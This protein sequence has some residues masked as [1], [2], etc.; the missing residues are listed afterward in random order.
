M[1]L[2]S[3]QLKTVIIELGT[4]KN[5]ILDMKIMKLACLGA[6]IQS[7]NF[8]DPFPKGLSKYYLQKNTGW[9]LG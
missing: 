2:T 5:F 1:T 4:H 8:G 9:L 3:I 7:C 6:E